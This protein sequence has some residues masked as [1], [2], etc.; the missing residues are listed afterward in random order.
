MA[1]KRGLVAEHLKRSHLIMEGCSH[2]NFESRLSP[3]QIGL[4]ELQRV[5]KEPVVN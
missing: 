5:A 3:P 2:Q 1:L 4:L